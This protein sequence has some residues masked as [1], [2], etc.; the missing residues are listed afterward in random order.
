MK[1]MVLAAVLVGCGGKATLG[2]I[3]DKTGAAACRRAGECFRANYDQCFQ[4]FKRTCCIDA[5]KC[6]IEPADIDDTDAFLAACVPAL[7]SADCAAQKAGV[8]PS[9]CLMSR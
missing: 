2:E 6:Q 3:C 1:W 5:N 8:L 4:G 7:E 9:A